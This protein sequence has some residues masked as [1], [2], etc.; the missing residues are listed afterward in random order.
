MLIM[1]YWVISS[2]SVFVIALS[3]TGII[4]PQ[5]LLIAFRRKLFDEPDPRKI[6]KGTIP[7][8]GGMAFM[9]SIFFAIACIC[10]ISMLFY[11][12]TFSN[13]LYKHTVNISFASCSL[14]LMFLV[15]LAD[16]L[17]GVKYRAKF[18][19]QI[20]AALFLVGASLSIDNLWGFLWIDELWAPLGWGLTI[21]VAV[22]ITNAI[23]LIDGIDGLASGLSAVACLYYGIVFFTAQEYF[24]AFVAFA[25]LGTL[26]PFFYY[27]VFGDP[28]KQEKIFMGDTGAL[29]IGII[30]TILSIRIC[31]EGV[32]SSIG[33]NPLVVAFTPLIVPCFDVLRVYLHRIRYHRNPFLPDKCHIHHKLLALG[34]P[35]TWAMIFIV[36]SSIIFTMTNLL[37]SKYIHVTILVAIDVAGYAGINILLTYYIHKRQRKL[38][39]NE[40]YA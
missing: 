17:I 11:E 10:G 14:M 3:L 31:H 26:V 27:N 12:G 28:S 4:I 20:V 35:K 13:E 30:M 33:V 38:N 36:V 25:T 23:N 40:Y 5:I 16:D 19:V 7:R 15:G 39:N 9:P 8:L 2:I 29:T 1:D 22:Y 32:G 24:Y 18:V 37:I 21:L 34:V 6:H